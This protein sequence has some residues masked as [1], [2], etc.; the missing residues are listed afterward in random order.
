MSV[1]DKEN[2]LIQMYLDAWWQ[3]PLQILG[4]LALD[5]FK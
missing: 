3:V 4:P 5:K 2:A 1:K